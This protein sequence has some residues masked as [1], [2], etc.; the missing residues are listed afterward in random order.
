[1]LLTNVLILSQTVMIFLNPNHMLLLPQPKEVDLKIII[2][3]VSFLPTF[4]L[5]TDYVH[6]ISRNGT[7]P[8]KLEV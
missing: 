7:F 5:K 8:V 6:L 1:M 2:I 4:M 3:I